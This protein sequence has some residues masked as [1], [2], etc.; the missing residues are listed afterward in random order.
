MATPRVSEV[1]KE[2]GLTHGGFYKHFSSREE[3]VAEA[4]D[5]AFADGEQDRVGHSRIR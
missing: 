5:R 2:P 4:V 1:M 3:L